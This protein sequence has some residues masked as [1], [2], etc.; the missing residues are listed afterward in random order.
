MNI[1]FNPGEH[2]LHGT[3]TDE[4]LGTFK[5]VGCCTLSPHPPDVI[6][7]ADFNNDGLKIY[8]QGHIHDEKIIS[9]PYV[10]KKNGVQ[11]GTGSFF[12]ELNSGD[13]LPNLKKV[14][15]T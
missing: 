2:E 13:S 4:E 6:F 14:S 1:L 15:D 3:G 10:M 7:T 8:Y 5:F 11:I 12:I 9:G